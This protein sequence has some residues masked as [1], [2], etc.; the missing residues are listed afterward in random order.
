MPRVNRT[1]TTANQIREDGAIAWIRWAIYFGGLDYSDVDKELSRRYPNAT[2]ATRDAV[3]REFQESRSSAGRYNR[4]GDT[5]KSRREDMAVNP[6]IPQAYRYVV[7]VEF[8]DTT[9][10]E[11]SGFFTVVD[12]SRSLTKAEVSEQA[13]AN[14]ES[15]Y[16][17]KT[18]PLDSPPGKIPASTELEVKF[19]TVECRTC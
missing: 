13:R 6:S 2:K 3:R 19:I 17:R 11:R 10:G 7:N 14:T 9:T 15:R 12:S 4:A 18:N 8:I 5:Y 16:A 1:A